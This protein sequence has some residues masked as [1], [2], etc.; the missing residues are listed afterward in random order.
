[1]S[2]TIKR[3]PKKQSRRTKKTKGHK[4]FNAAKTHPASLMLPKRKH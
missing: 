3:R 2:S 4:K 1:M